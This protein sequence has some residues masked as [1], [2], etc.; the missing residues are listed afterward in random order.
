MY[1]A[2]CRWCHAVY[3]WMFYSKDNK[4]KNVAVIEKVENEEPPTS[5]PN[6]S[7]SYFFDSRKK[8]AILNQAE[9]SI[10]DK[11][12]TLSE[13]GFTDSELNRKLLAM[14]DGDIVKVVK[15]HLGC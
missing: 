7:D 12:K 13:S 9:I 10:E 2:A 8:S 14:Y 3:T 5:Q 1:G 4:E 6:V 11:L 15:A